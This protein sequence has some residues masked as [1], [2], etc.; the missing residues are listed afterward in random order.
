MERIIGSEPAKSEQRE[1][2]WVSMSD[3][4]AGLMM[5]FLL[6][7]VAFMLHVQ[8]EQEK[9]KEVAVAYQNSQVALYQELYDEFVEDL[10]RWDAEIDQDSLEFRFN[11]PEVLF[12]TGKIGLKPG[13]Q[14][15]LSDFF[16]RYLAVIQRF[17]DAIAEVRI[18]GHTSSIWNRYST[19]DEAYFNNMEL[20]QGRTRAVL[21]Y[22]YFLPT[23]AESK[24]W[25][26]KN[27]AAVGFSSAHVVVDDKGVEDVNRSRRVSFKVVTN[28]ETQIRKIIAN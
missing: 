20:S 2:H 11:A 1:E 14:T 16:P 13:F 5:V 22:V 8:Q 15:I 26:K 18:E 23:V 19:A 6:I 9:V 25:I 3:L 12:D 28:A 10:P 7:S 27:F 4:M 21:N 24:E 17:Q